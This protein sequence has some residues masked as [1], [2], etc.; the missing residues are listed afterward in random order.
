MKTGEHRRGKRT[1]RDMDRDGGLSDVLF[2]TL[3][4][5][6]GVDVFLPSRWVYYVA[7]FVL[8]LAGSN[9]LRRIGSGRTK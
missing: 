5:A 4:L 7:V 6:M 3:V 9:A 1:A 2:A 8:M